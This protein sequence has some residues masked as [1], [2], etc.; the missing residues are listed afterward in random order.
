MHR[1]I[2]EDKYAGKQVG[3]QYVYLST[4]F[5]CL[6]HNGGLMTLWGGRFAQKLDQIAWD[7]NT[8]LPVDQRM[9]IQDVDGSLAWAE[10]IHRAGILSAG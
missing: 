2:Q 6:P 5:T 9:A 10:A 7:L 4:L 8:S 3:R 1:S